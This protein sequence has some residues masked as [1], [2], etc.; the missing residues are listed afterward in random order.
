M[1][2]GRKRAGGLFIAL[3]SVDWNRRYE[4]GFLSTPSQNYLVRI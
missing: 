4:Q 1:P 2:A 3:L